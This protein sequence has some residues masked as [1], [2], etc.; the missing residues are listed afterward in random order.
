MLRQKRDGQTATGS[1]LP[2]SE[3]DDLLAELTAT[4]D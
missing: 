2:E 4:H 1:P 3:E